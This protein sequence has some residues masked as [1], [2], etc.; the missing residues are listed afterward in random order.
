MITEREP[1]LAA[2]VPEWLRS[3]DRDYRSVAHLLRVDRHHEELRQ[4][5]LPM[6]DATQPT[7]ELAELAAK[8]T[9]TDDEAIRLVRVAGRLDA[10]ELPLPDIAKARLPRAIEQALLV[11][12][13]DPAVSRVSG[14]LARSNGW[15]LQA[16]L[17]TI[18]EARRVVAMLNTPGSMAPVRSSVQQSVRE[19]LALVE[20]M[21]APG[22]GVHDDLRPLLERTR[23]IFVRHQERLGG[24]GAVA[25]LNG[26]SGYARHPD[27]AEIGAAASNI[28][29]GAELLSAEARAKLAAR[30][31]AGAADTLAW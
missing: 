6:I 16:E 17:Q 22:S 2:V 30:E 23:E 12:G 14:N 24:Q 31:A 27:Y 26:V 8:E 21:L 3:H 5:L 28:E 9:L 15:Q 4:A 29:L 1:A 19:S 20:N 7:A 10:F 11:S 13:A 25:N 18:A